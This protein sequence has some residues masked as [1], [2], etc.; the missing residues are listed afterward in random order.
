M[1][2]YKQKIESHE[3]FLRDADEFCIY[4]LKMLK[5]EK[6]CPKSARWLGADEIKH[7]VQRIHTYLH[8]ANN[9]KV[10]NAEEKNQRHLA[11][12]NAY[13]LMR[14]LGEKFEFCSKIY[15]IDKNALTRWLNEKGNVQAW[16]SR[17]MKSDEKN[18]KDIK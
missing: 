8:W 1:P 11:Q 5:D 2:K 12:T 4:T 6:I 18:Y 15:N 14:T 9:I 16:I 13:A 3:K 17:W 7:L 10:T